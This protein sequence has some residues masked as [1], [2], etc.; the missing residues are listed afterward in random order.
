MTSHGLLARKI[1]DTVIVRYNGM[2][3][4]MTHKATSAVEPIIIILHGIQEFYT[5][6]HIALHKNQ[7]G[8]AFP[9]K[10]AHKRNGIGINGSL[11]AAVRH[12][13]VAE[14]SANKTSRHNI[15]PTVNIT[16]IVTIVHRQ[17]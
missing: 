8:Q 4:Q 15:A 1:G 11:K 9:Y 13:D 2:T 5:P 7:M 17:N 14:G 10:A 6:L 16:A 12:V 3:G